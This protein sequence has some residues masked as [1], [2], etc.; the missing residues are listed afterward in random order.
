VFSYNV[1]DSLATQYTWNGSLASLHDTDITLNPL[2]ALANMSLENLSGVYNFNVKILT[3]NGSVDQ[4]TTNNTYQSSFIV[5]PSW[6]STFVVLFVTNNEGV[7]AV[8]VNPSQT[9]WEITD[10]NNNVLY[11][12]LTPSIST[13]YNDTVTLPAYGYYK[14]SITDGGCNG[15]QWWANPSNITAGAFVVTQFSTGIPIPMNGYNYSGTFA[16]DFGCGFV[17]YFTTGASS[18]GIRTFGSKNNSISI[19]A[20]PNPAQDNV[21]VSISG[22]QS[23][24]GTFE[25]ID[26]LGQT[27]LQQKANGIQNTINLN[28]MPNGIYTITYRDAQVSQIQTRMVITK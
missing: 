13:T 8:G 25:V 9:T 26:G 2:T 14:L 16:N 4:D 12:Q 20:Y 18:A 10:M 28:G 11:S 6:P 17:Q 22:L 7:S 19:N 21:N 24:N 3:V 15:L 5:A 23:A 1:K 27:V